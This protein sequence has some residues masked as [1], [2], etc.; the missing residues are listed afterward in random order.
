MDE[1]GLDA[2]VA[3]RPQN[4]LYCT[5]MYSLGHW[6]MESVDAY[7]ILPRDPARPVAL[8]IPISDADL[9]AERNIPIE[10]VHVYGTFF[11]EPGGTQ[12]SPGASPGFSHEADERLREL[13]LLSPAKSA[14]EALIAALAGS[15]SSGWRVGIDE[16]GMPAP[17][18]AAIQERLP[19][20]RFLPVGDLLIRARMVKTAA[21]RERL[22]RAAAVTEQAMMAVIASLQ[23][24]MTELEAQR[25]LESSMVSLGAKPALS[26]IGFGPHSA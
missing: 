16:K 6:L 18:Q 13:A 26:V 9:L 19:Q 25:L 10:K 15:V 5:E 17:T 8:V 12:G 14:E 11:V 23:E 2:I 20:V 24:G 7:G 22:T 4:V 3:A 21:E 1:A